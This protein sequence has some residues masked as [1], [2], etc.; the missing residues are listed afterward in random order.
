MVWGLLHIFCKIEKVWIRFGIIISFLGFAVSPFYGIC[1]YLGFILFVLKG[2]L[3]FWRQARDAL[4]FGW[5]VGCSQLRGTC[6]G[7]SWELVEAATVEEGPGVVA[8]AWDRSPEVLVMKANMTWQ[9]WWAN[10]WRAGAVGLIPGAVAIA[11]LG[12]VISLILPIK[13]LLVSSYLFQVYFQFL[14]WSF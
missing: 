10:S 5:T 2:M 13:F 14:M 12:S 3:K 4:V 11:T 7:H 1:A 9:W 6:G 8:P